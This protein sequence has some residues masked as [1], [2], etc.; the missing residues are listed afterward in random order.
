MDSDGDWQR[1]VQI[2]E[3][4]L[5]EAR[6]SHDPRCLAGDRIEKAITV[7]LDSAIVIPKRPELMR[8]RI[9]ALGAVAWL[10]WFRYGLGAPEDAARNLIIAVDMF[11]FVGAA[12]SHVPAEVELFLAARRGEFVMFDHDYLS[13]TARACRS[14]NCSTRRAVCSRKRLGWRPRALQ[15]RL[16]FWATWLE[17]VSCS[18]RRLGARS[19]PSRRWITPGGRL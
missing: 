16:R 11:G 9:T 17:S 18:Q 13:S 7:V 1:S 19:L 14:K 5:A 3:E 10:C 15:M 12:L 6:L 8:S 4:A 2:I